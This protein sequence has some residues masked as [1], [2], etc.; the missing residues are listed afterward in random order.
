MVS[1]IDTNFF[2][3]EAIDDP[4]SLYDQLRPHGNVVFNDLMQGWNVFGF[5]EV[6]T[7]L[8]DGGERFTELNGIRSSSIGSTRP[9]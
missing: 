5:D 9:T 4:Y 3:P 7:V 6:T 2:T 1:H 8:T